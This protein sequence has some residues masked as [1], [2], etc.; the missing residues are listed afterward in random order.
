MTF[1]ARN[2]KHSVSEVTL[3]V[4]FELGNSQWKLGFTTGLAQQARVSTVAARDRQAVLDE[5]ANAKK[6]F[7]LAVDAHAVSCYEAGRD[8]FWLHRFLV[9][10]GIENVVVDSSSIEVNR[11]ARRA[12]TDRLDVGKLLGMLLRYCGACCMCRV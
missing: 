11:R 4:A 12:K 10:H 6:R 3:H 1:T 8:G 2:E 9:A 5:V 7:G